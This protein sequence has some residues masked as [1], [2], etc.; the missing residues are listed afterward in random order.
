MEGD[1]D[2]SIK[3]PKCG[4]ENLENAS[5]CAECGTNLKSTKTDKCTQCGAEIMDSARFCAECGNDILSS[6]EKAVPNICLSCGVENPENS[7]FCS[8]CGKLMPVDET[9]LTTTNFCPECSFKNPENSQF[10]AE[11][12]KELPLI[13]KFNE[14][15]CQNCGQMNVPE[16]VFC[17]ECGKILLKKKSSQSVNRPRRAHPASEPK[18]KR[19][20]KSGLSGLLVSK[21]KF[22][23]DIDKTIIKL[24]EKTQPHLNKIDSKLD[25]LQ[26]YR[27][28]E[29]GQ[30]YLICD[31]CGGYY[32]L[33]H[34]ESPD[35]FD[36]CGCGGKLN[37]SRTLN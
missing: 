31:T 16:S 2:S 5:F 26:N 9:Q 32:E 36:G 17:A 20:S 24:E 23:N 33:Q 29:Y 35:D 30:G 21:S 18:T 6:S 14:V 7:K 4:G 25:E 1:N 34:D 28:K 13:N 15:V 10:C 3:C 37:F 19:K 27:K 12:G 11:C 22:V 8:E